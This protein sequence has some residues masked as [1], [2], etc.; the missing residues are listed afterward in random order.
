MFAPKID[1]DGVIYKFKTRLVDHGDRQYVFVPDPEDDGGWINLK[2]LTELKTF[3]PSVTAAPGRALLSM[4]TSQ[5]LEGDI[6]TAFLNGDLRAEVYFLQ[7][8]GFVNPNPNLVWRLQ[9]A[10]WSQTSTSVQVVEADH[11][12]ERRWV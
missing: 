12:L 10:L 5:E 8:L 7:P 2:G 3:T 4:A 1:G 6:K 9:E 11:R